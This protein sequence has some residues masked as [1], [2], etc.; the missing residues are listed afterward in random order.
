MGHA[1]FVAD[2]HGDASILAGMSKRYESNRDCGDRMI[3]VYA[4]CGL[5]DIEPRQKARDEIL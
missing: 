2:L 3:I 5:E 1:I 4:P